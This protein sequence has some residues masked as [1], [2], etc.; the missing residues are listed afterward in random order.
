MKKTIVLAIAAA[1][2]VSTPLAAFA[3]PPSSDSHKPKTTSTAAKPA[4]SENTAGVVAS[5]MADTR[6]L[7]LNAGEEFK[8][9]TTVTDAN[10]KAGDKVNV[11][12]TMKDGSRIA[13]KVTVKP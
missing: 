4:R 6:M 1:L 9:A 5:W 3:A 11:H 2:A 12:W 10:Y 7:K 8:V 13:D